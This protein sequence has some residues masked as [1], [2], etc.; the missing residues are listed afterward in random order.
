MNENWKRH[1]QAEP[2]IVFRAPGRVNLIGEHTDY[3]NGFVLPMAIEKTTQVA[4]NT[5]NLNTHRIYSANTDQLIEH[6]AAITTIETSGWA[7][8][9]LGVIKLLG[10]SEQGFDI[11]IESSVPI[12]AGLS[13][14]AALECSVAAAI[15][16]LLNLGLDN[17]QLAKICQRAENEVVGAPTGN[18]DQIASLFG[19]ADSAVFIDCLTEDIQPIELGFDQAGLEL[20][21]IDTKTSHALS[22][23]DYGNRRT[24]CYSAAKTLGID[25]L[26]ELN[27]LE[28]IEKLLPETEQKRVRH[29]FT[30]NQ[31]VLDAV[32]AI[33]DKDFN[34]L[35]KLMNESHNSMRDDFEISTDELNTAVEAS[36]AS[37]ALGARMTGGGFGGS[38]IA[39][40]DSKYSEAL[41]FG[42][43][44][45]FQT[46]GFQSPDVFTVK[47]SE[48]AKQIAIN[49][50]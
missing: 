12:G 20:V 1:F 45:A 46:R 19:Q 44:L 49:I 10:I 37:G 26:R 30:E 3:N 39:L 31:R 16:E 28:G 18:M 2:Q 9:P 8:Y 48:G 21:V 11:A 15:N 29:I 5:N 36:I 13:S 32:Q 35:G 17:L 42:I 7:R 24:E 22:D 4:I 14:S 25:S 23:G 43:Q 40:V 38:A 47:P 34:A 33:R 50:E 6:P 27:Q 41:G